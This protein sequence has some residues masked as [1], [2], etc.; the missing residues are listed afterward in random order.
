MIPKILA[1]SLLA[2]GAL[3]VPLDVEIEKRISCPGVHIFGARETTVSPGYGSSITVVN[4]LLNAYPGSTAEAISYPACGGQSSCGS[5]SYSNSVAQGIAAV[6]SAVNSY[7][8]Q[9]PSTKLVLVGYSQGGEIMDAALCGGGVP[10]QGYTNTAVQLSTSAVGMVKAAI[11]MGDPLYVAGLSYDV[12]TCAAGGFDARPSGFFCPSAS[13]IQSYCDSTDPYCCNGSNAATH[14]GYGAEYGAQAIAFVKIKRRHPRPDSYPTTKAQAPSSKLPPFHMASHI[15][16]LNTLRRGRGRGRGTSRTEEAGL[17]SGKDRIVQG[18]DN[19]ASVSRLSAVELGYLEDV[20]AAALTPAGSATRRLPIINRGTYARTTAIDQLVARFLG[21]FSPGNTHKKQIISLG[22]G[23]DT[24]VFR[25]LSSRQ[26][27]DFVYHELD[28]AVNTAEKIRAIRSA[29]LLQRAL[30]IDSS[31]ASS[32][33]DT[34]VTVSEAGDALH[35]P[36]YHVHPVDLRSLSTCS[37]PAGALPGVETELPTLLI[38]ECCLVYLSPTEAEQVVAFFTQ[39]LFGQPLSGPGD[40]LQ[41]ARVNVAPL[42][43]ILYEPI[44]PNDAFGRTMVS[45]LAA[46]GIQLKT[47]ARYAS[48]EAQRDR[49]QDQGF[50]DGQAAADIEFIWKRWVNEDEKERVAGLEMLDEMEEWQLLA[51]HYCIAWGWRDRD[52]V[53]AFAG[54]K[55]LQA[56]QGE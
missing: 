17:P 20:Y 48:L 11:F 7:N 45:N 27:P 36:S 30:G 2:G 3:A 53:L 29:P 1:F 25:L 37:D 12:G 28:F 35:S 54:W 42:G 14:Q 49:F 43:L 34:R 39:R 24:R 55:D 41:E 23:S 26:T 9:C 33:K 50:G 40:I 32:E 47:L 31:Q 13:K 8:T 18:T 21:P 52:D 6:A 56:Q 4:G 19:D 15:P 5:V 46:R 38:S 51:R 10:N 22:A 16:N 44:R